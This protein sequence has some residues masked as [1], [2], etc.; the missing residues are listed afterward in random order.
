MKIDNLV[1]D[2]VRK[3]IK[4]LYIK[5]YPPEGKILIVSPQRLDDA[6]IKKSVIANI[7]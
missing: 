5:I 2:L 6:A 7:V 3:D 4:H 1:V